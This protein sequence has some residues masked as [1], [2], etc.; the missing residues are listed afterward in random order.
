MSLFGELA[1]P[2]YGLSEVLLNAYSIGIAGTEIELGGRMPLIG[3]LSPPH[4]C[5]SIVT[6]YADSVIVTGT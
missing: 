4:D 5:Y 6:C 2:Y 1:I 3:S